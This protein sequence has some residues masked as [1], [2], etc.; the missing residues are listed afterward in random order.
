MFGKSKSQKTVTW[1]NGIWTLSETAGAAF[2]SV[3]TKCNWKQEVECKTSHGNLKTYQ[4]E[5]TLFKKSK[6]NL[7]LRALAKRG[8]SH[9]CVL[10]QTGEPFFF[11]RWQSCAS[12]CAS[13]VTA[14]CYWR[15]PAMMLRQE[16]RDL[17]CSRLQPSSNL[18]IL[19]N[20]SHWMVRRKGEDM[21]EPAGQRCS[22]SQ[23]ALGW[24]V[25]ALSIS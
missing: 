9:P 5:V 23:N 6:K 11:Q 2:Y 22:A 1:W 3:Y 13:S 25:Q 15:L 4:M 12:C 17:P 24:H 7:L 20:G 10:S 8:A 18:V 21:T 16:L 14:L 19:V